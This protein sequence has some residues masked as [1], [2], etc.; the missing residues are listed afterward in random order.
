MGII[1]TKPTF[2][3]GEYIF[4]SVMNS[5]FSD[6]IDDLNNLDTREALLLLLSGTR[7]MTGDLNM[8]THSV[9]CS[10]IIERAVGVGVT[11]DGLLIK[12]NIIPNTGYPNALLLN[13]TRAMT[14]DFLPDSDIARNTGSA[15]LR[16]NYLHARYGRLNSL[17]VGAIEPF[18]G[19]HFGMNDLIVGLTSFSCVWDDSYLTLQGSDTNPGRI[20]I[21]GENAAA[22][23]GQI[24]FY[25]TD[26]T[27][28]SQVLAMLIEGVTNTPKLQV[29]YGIKVDSI[30]EKT[31]AVG[32]TID[33]CLIKD[34]K[35]ADSL[36]L[37]TKSKGLSDGNI[38]ELPI[39]TEGQVLRRGAAAWEAGSV[40]AGGDACLV[41]A[42]SNTP[43]TLKDRADYVCNGVND[44]V[45]INTAFGIADSVV[46]CPGTFT[47]HGSI[48]MGTSQSLFGSGFGT[49][50]DIAGNYKAIDNSDHGGGNSGI[51]TAHLKINGNSHSL[52]YG[53]KFD[54]VQYSSIVDCFIIGC[55][56]SHYI[57]NSEHCGIYNNIC[58]GNDYG[59]SIGAGLYKGSD[60]ITVQG[61]IVR[62]S[63]HGGIYL[64]NCNNVSVKNNMVSESSQYSSLAH[65]NIYV[66]GDDPCYT[67]DIQGNTI[68]K[69]VQTNKPQYAINVNAANVNCCLISSNDCFEGGQ[70]GTFR[71]QGTNTS[72]GAGNR[73]ND[74]S[75]ATGT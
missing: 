9:K 34:G 25:A 71:D 35:V 13:G 42:A 53:I 55:H 67:C 70:T 26:A 65:S 43:A 54:N 52:A 33:E 36:K 59:P 46:L 3:A 37:D 40:G 30:A 20:N 48:L 10:S 51:H 72:W 58:I 16:W 21:Y 12:D 8:A 23:P 69:G 39:A 2:V 49:L 28:A 17:K 15:A 5:E 75:W 66:G 24:R 27:K 61:C 38:C 29:E 64:E 47:L 4:A 22:Y 50:L 1:S 63:L 56:D 14:G 60:Y 32:V 74:G 57:I 73:K 18:T 11:V 19:V 7:A 45:E 62:L 68:R 41:V 44:Q 6:V 31:G